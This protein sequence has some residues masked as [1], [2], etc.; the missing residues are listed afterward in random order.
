MI[1]KDMEFTFRPGNF[2]IASG[3]LALAETAIN[4]G[5]HY[6]PALHKL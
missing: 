1:L 5:W 6:V 2:L 3:G 4:K